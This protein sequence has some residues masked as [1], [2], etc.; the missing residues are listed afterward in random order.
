MEHSNTCSIVIIDDG[1][2]LLNAYAHDVT[3]LQSHAVCI[4]GSNLGQVDSACGYGI[5][6]LFIVFTAFFSVRSIHSMLQ[7]SGLCLAI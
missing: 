4:F 1:A 7:A 6:P 2:S 5:K 3:T